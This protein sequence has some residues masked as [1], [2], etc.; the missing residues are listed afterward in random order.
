MSQ[1]ATGKL[2]HSNYLKQNLL[3]GIVTQVMDI[4]KIQTA[5]GEQ[6]RIQQH[7]EAAKPLNWSKQRKKCLHQGPGEE[8]PTGAML[9]CLAVT[10]N[11]KE[12]HSLLETP[13]KA[14]S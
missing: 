3:Q 9:A 6:S 4:L 10:G 14:S 12:S 1:N 7:Q 5:D 13:P 8:L 11:N 2:Y